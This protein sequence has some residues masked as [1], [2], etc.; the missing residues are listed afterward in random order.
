[1]V[2]NKSLDIRFISSKDQIADIFTKPLSS[3]RFST[4]QDKLKVVPLSLGLRGHVED[5]I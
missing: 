2:T 5:N 1:M 4:L 3:L